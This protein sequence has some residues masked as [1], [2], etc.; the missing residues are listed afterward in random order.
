EHST[1]HYSS[2]IDLIKERIRYIPRSDYF[3]SSD[4][5]FD[6]ILRDTLIN[7]L[8][9]TS[10][11]DTINFRLNI[12]EFRE[13]FIN[14]FN[15]PSSYSGYQIEF[16]KIFDNF[17][18]I[19]KD[20]FIKQYPQYDI[21]NIVKQHVGDILRGEMSVVELRKL[22]AQNIINLQERIDAFS[23]IIN[24]KNNNLT[25]EVKKHWFSSLMLDTNFK[26]FDTW[27]EPF[28]DCYEVFSKA[29][30]KGMEHMSMYI[31]QYN[32]ILEDPKA[33]PQE[34]E[35]KLSEIA[36]E[37]ADLA[38]DIYD[39]VELKDLIGGLP[40]ATEIILLENPDFLKLVQNKDFF[41]QLRE[42]YSQ[43]PSSVTKVMGNSLLDAIAN[44]VKNFPKEL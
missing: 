11:F 42:K 20:E 32:H 12:N 35:E 36:N 43:I 8:L 5:N 18:F 19:T 24:K 13:N 15:S 28:M 26:D 40:R 22:V 3:K 27:N 21:S 17:T 44:F 16:D 39:T 4:N 29:T 37:I 41:D 9:N 30:Y 34:R 1:G 38:K 7:E 25:D 6:K 14:N 10:E 31:G 2:K 23:T 33:T